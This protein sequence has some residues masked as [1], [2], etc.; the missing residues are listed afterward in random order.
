M[1]VS[2][3]TRIYR[4]DFKGKPAYS[5]RIASKEFKDGERT[6]NWI[7]VYEPV[8]FPKGTNLANKTDITVTKGFEA[9]YKGNDGEIKRKL[10][11]QEFESEDNGFAE[12]DEDVPF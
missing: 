3:K 4:K 1:E 9:V 5:R 6:E 7:G 11:V 10:I 2:G 8:Q 12:V